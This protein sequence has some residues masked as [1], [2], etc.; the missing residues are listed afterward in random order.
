MVKTHALPSAN[1]PTHDLLAALPAA[2]YARLGP[3]LAVIPLK[4]KRVLHKPGESIEKIYFPGGGFCSV[5]TILEDGTMVE[6]ATIGR[7]GMVGISAVLDGG[8][9]A[10]AAMVQAETDTC[11]AMAVDAFRSEM[12]LGG[13]FCSLLTRYAHALV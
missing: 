3:S 11:Y 12:H 5:L 8:P 13:N 10:S 1:R 9:S 2:D 4:L 6:V 7:E